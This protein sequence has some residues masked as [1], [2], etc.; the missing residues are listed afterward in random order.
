MK[1]GLCGV[2]RKRLYETEAIAAEAATRKQEEYGKP[3]WPYQYDYCGHWH[4]TTK[5]PRATNGRK[6]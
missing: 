4:L 2:T 1:W 5:A 3:A 6:R